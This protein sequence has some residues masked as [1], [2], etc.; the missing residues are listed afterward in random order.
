MLPSLPEPEPRKNLTQ[1]L[2]KSWDV[3]LEAGGWGA[4]T[5]GGLSKGEE[6][7]LIFPKEVERTARLKL[8]AQDLE[9]L[10]SFL[11][12]WNWGKAGLMLFSSDTWA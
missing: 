8:P 12:Q 6:S 11:Y 5:S 10:S 9:M 3:S 2:V 1:T 7:I 4:G